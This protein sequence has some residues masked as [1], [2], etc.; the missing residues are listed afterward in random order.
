MAESAVPPVTP[1]AKPKI[2]TDWNGE[3]LRLAVAGGNIFMS[4][5]GATV[6]LTLR[7]SSG[8]RC[9]LNLTAEQADDLATSLASAAEIIRQAGGRFR[10][11]EPAGGENTDG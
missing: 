2:D 7:S 1:G 5:E 4:R 10:E 11:N 8:Y 9:T 6:D 3:F